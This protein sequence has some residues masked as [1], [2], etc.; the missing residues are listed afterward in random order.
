MDYGRTNYAPDEKRSLI[1]KMI[2]YLVLMAVGLTVVYYLSQWLYG[3]KT[4]QATTLISGRIPA[5]AAPTVVGA[6]P[7]IYEGGE[8]SINFWTY[9]ANWKASIGKRKHIVEIGTTNMSTLV[10]GLGGYKNTLM[11]RV[12]NEAVLANNTLTAARVSALFTQLATD[13][14]TEMD[15][16][17]MPMCDLPEIDLQR[18]VNVSVVIAGR[19]IDVYL[20]GKLQRSCVM[21]SYFKVDS[22]SPLLAKVLQHSGFDGYIS[23]LNAYNYALDPKQI[24]HMFMAGPNGTDTGV[25]S[26]FKNLFTGGG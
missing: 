26:W 15:V 7:M 24:Y 2:F 16:A 6:P 17:D 10:V 5:N 9:I 11:V 18:W 20:D 8:V 21:P 19:S 25:L 22:T 13:E 3:T 4:L 1:M 12:Q 23:N 14:N